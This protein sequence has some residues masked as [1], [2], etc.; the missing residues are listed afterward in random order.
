MSKC[1]NKSNSSPGVVFVIEGVSILLLDP[2]EAPAKD[3]ANI[4]LRNIENQL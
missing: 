4:N 1:C 2:K 3:V